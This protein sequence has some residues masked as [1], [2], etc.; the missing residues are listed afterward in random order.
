MTGVD[1]GESEKTRIVEL[2][3]KLRDP[4]YMDGAILRI[5]MVMSAEL[6]EENKVARR[7][8]RH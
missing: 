6:V 5:A 4:S 1:N 3:E 2:K 8:Q 7:Q